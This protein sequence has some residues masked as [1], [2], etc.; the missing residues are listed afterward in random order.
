MLRE[1]KEKIM[2]ILAQLPPQLLTVITVALIL[3]LTLVPHPLGDEELPIFPGAD[4][5]VHAIMFGWLTLMILLDRQRRRDWR[6]LGNPV[7][8]VAAIIP[9]LFGILIE[10]LQ[11]GMALG[12]GF[13]IADML[14]DTAGAFIAS[15]LWLLLQ[16]HWSRN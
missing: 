16:H 8:W 2:R 1:K 4:K 13:E 10:Y 11:W 3:W 12:R 7:I 5:I 6:R 9:S 14:A 15:T